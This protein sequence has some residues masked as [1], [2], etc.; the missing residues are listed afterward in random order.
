MGKKKG[1]TGKRKAAEINEEENEVDPELEAEMQALAAIRAEKG[2]QVGSDSS[3]EDEDFDDSGSYRT[4]ATRET[5]ARDLGERPRR[6]TTVRVHSETTVRDQPTPP[7]TLVTPP[8]PH[9]VVPR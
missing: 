8:R 2:G 9:P 6:G 3:D 7:R 1:M 5:S 4:S